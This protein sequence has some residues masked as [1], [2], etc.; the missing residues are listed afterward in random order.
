MSIENSALPVGQPALPIQFSKSAAPQAIWSFP[1]LP[2]TAL[3]LAKNPLRSFPSPS[4][5][6]FIT[7]GREGRVGREMPVLDWG[8]ACP[9]SA[10]PALEVGHALNCTLWSPHDA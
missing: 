4:L 10:L 7:L 3:P 1:A 6:L 5:S 8:F 9:T 2:A